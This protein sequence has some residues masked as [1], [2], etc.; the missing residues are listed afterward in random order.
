MCEL[1]HLICWCVL[2]GGVYAPL[3]AAASLT[4][5]I[6]DY[7]RKLPSIQSRSFSLDAQWYSLPGTAATAN[8]CLGMITGYDKISR[9]ARESLSDE[10]F[11][12]IQ[13]GVLAAKFAYPVPGDY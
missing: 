6:L 9:I 12:A 11:N 4:V 5:F 10:L 13:A 3:Y 8:G 7:R 2:L 1:P